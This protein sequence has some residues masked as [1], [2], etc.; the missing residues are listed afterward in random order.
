MEDRLLFLLKGMPPLEGF[1]EGAARA[2]YKFDNFL[3][4]KFVLK[5]AQRLYPEDI[6][7]FVVRVAEKIWPDSDSDRYKIALGAAQALYPEDLP[8]QAEFMLQVGQTIHPEAESDKIS[9]IL[10]AVEA[11]SRRSGKNILPEFSMILAQRFHPN[12]EFRQ[13]NFIGNT[14]W[15]V[16]FKKGWFIGHVEYAVDA[17]ESVAMSDIPSQAKFAS[18]IATCYGNFDALLGFVREVAKRLYKGDIAAESGFLAEVA[19]TLKFKEEDHRFTFIAEI[20]QIMYWGNVKLQGR[21]IALLIENMFSGDLS[22]KKEFAAKVKEKLWDY[23]YRY[24]YP[25]DKARSITDKLFNRGGSS[26]KYRY[27]TEIEE[28]LKGFNFYPRE[29]SDAI[30]ENLSS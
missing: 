25:L 18:G 23:N 21:V 30:A 2:L 19:Q 12:D 11:S 16:L 13:G 24:G 5:A 9:C 17:I 22:R 27:I 1:I 4:G 3:R 7:G 15:N 14:L 29:L 10:W 6:K 26:E 8:S 20:G 28:K